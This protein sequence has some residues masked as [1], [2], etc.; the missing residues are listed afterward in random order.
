MSL[1][2]PDGVTRVLLVRHGET[3]ENVQG[4]VQGQLDTPLNAVGIQQAQRTGAAL[5]VEP[6]ARIISSPLQRTRDTAHH[7]AAHH[8]VQIETD[9]RLMERCFGVLQGQVY[10]GP[11]QKPEDTEGIEPSTAMRA[12]LASFWDDLVA[13]VRVSAPRL[14]VLVSHGGALSTLVNQV[15]LTRGDVVLHEGLEPSRFWNCSITDIHLRAEEPGLIVRWADTAH[16]EEA[17]HVVNVDE[18]EPAPGNA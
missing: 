12:R 2:A 17:T 3:N 11:A 9:P 4:I 6:V 14:V 15:L 10:R 16:L 8:D 18:A 5:Q 7:I 13:D 1:A